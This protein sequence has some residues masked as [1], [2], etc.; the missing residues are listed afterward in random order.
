MTLTVL[1]WF[2]G[3]ILAMALFFGLHHVCIYA[4]MRL[5]YTHH[6]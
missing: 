6:F 3:I 1:P 4:Y 2:T 5:L